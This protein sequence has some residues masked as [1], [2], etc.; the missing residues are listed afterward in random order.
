VLLHEE[1]E[2]G[3]WFRLRNGMMFRLVVLDQLSDQIKKISQLM[4]FV[5]ADCINEA[6]GPQGT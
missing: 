6:G 1:S 3:P 5:V 2:N 4:A